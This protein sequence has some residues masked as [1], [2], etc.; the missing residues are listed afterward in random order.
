MSAKNKVDS[1]VKK[2][3]EKHLKFFFFDSNVLLHCIYYLYKGL[4]N[5]LK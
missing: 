1:I 2:G 4:K 5:V 3:S